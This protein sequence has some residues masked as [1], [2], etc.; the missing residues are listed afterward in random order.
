MTVEERL[1]ALYQLQQ[2][3]SKI[4]DLRTLAESEADAKTR[5]NALKY[6]NEYESI[7][8]DALTSYTAI[9]ADVTAHNDIVKAHRN[10]N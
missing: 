5:N 3:N 4:D 6:I 8:A 10:N 2:V 1:R 9:C 7:V